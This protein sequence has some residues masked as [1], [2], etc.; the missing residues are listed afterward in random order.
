MNL[1]RNV[2]QAL[3]LLI[4][5]L[6]VGLTM[7]LERATRVDDRPSSGKSRH[8][9]DVIVDNFTVRRFDPSGQVQHTL[10]AQQ[11][12]HY[13][14][15]DTTELDKPLLLYRGK[16]SPTRISAE[17]ALLTKD[18]KEAI[19]RDNV[20]V[21]REAS[22]GNPEM[23]LETS[24]LNVYPDD[25]IARTDQPVKLTQGKSV[26]HGVGMVADRVKQTYILESRVKATLERTRRP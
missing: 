7:W 9:P 26:A 24:V 3:P 14:D 22:P 20:R 2:Q 21:L 23:T 5:I 10:T 6:L 18:G 19:L 12:R 25:E 11:L 16:Q 17:R 4:L 1:Q 13:P 15:D 8:D